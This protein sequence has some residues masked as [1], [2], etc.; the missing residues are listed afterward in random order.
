MLASRKVHQ[1]P[2]ATR[3]GSVKAATAIKPD[4][5]NDGHIEALKN[6]GYVTVRK[7]IGLTGI[8]I[9]SGQMMCEAGSDYNIVERRRVMDKACRQIRAAQ[10]FYLNDT[11][12]VGAD[13]SPEGL[14][15]FT[16]QSESPLRIMKTNGEIS[17]GYVVIPAGQNILST[18][19]LRT[20]I[21]IVPLGK[22]SY[23]EN[24]IAYS[25]PALE[26]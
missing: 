25:N 10:L 7:I 3:D 6:A 16:A 24:E 1:G 8:Y 4:G 15:M 12:K 19:T 5:L 22:M 2:D 18:S 9:T 13:G 21:R 26:A 14:E 17:S 23:I 11:V 20:K